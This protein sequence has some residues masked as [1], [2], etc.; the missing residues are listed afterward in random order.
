[1]WYINSTEENGAVHTLCTVAFLCRATPRESRISLLKT[2]CP[3]TTFVVWFWR[4][5]SISRRRGHLQLLPGIAAEVAKRAYQ[6]RYGGTNR[7]IRLLALSNKIL[8]SRLRRIQQIRCS[9]LSIAQILGKRFRTQV[10]HERHRPSS[11]S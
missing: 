4:F 6:N 3:K 7:A 8:A 1:M 10:P 11:L 5:H 9:I 2:S